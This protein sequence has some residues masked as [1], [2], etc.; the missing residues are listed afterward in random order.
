[1]NSAACIRICTCLLVDMST[2]LLGVHLGQ[3][4]CVTQ[5][6]DVQLLVIATVFSRL[7]QLFLLLFCCVMSGSR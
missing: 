2:F 1:M 5:C 4:C 7:C 3:N 6:A